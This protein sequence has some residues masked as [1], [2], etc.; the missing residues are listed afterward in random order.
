[1]S[2]F[3]AFCAEKTQERLLTLTFMLPVTWSPLTALL[4]AIKKIIC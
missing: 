3:C 1:M 4:L 2:V